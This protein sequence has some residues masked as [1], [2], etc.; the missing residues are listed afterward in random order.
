MILTEVELYDPLN[1][2]WVLFEAIVDTG[3]TYC[4]IAEHVAHKLGLEEREE[5]H[6]WQVENPAVSS[7]VLLKLRFGQKSYEVETIAVKIKEEYRRDAT[8]DEDCTRPFHP[9][10]LTA[11]VLLGLNFLQLLP[12]EEYEGLMRLE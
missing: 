4:G 3:A 8:P 9:H 6:L 2:A 7:I 11:R 12:I 1:R 5:V 10:P